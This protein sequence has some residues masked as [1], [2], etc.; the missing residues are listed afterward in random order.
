[1]FLINLIEVLTKSTDYY[2][3]KDEKKEAIEDY[4]IEEISKIPTETDPNKLL[5]NSFKLRSWI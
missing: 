2:K 1:M 5:L 3:D 4:S